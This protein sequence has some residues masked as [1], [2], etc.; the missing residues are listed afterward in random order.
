MMN[1][2]EASFYSF[3][4]HK[5]VSIFFITILLFF[6]QS[7]PSNND[8]KL[9][10]SSSCGKI[11]NISYPFRLKTDPNTCGDT[12][13]ELE[14]HNNM[15]LL[16][17]LFSGKYYVQDIDYKK[18]T[19]HVSDV[20]VIED[21]ICSFIPSYFLYEGSFG[22][23]F[24]G[25]GINPFKLDDTMRISYFNCSNMIIDDDKYVNVDATPCGSRGHIYVV[26]DNSSN[27]NFSVKDIKIGCQLK[28][29]T[30][31]NWTT[32]K[33]DKNKNNNVSYVD[34]HNMLVY[35]FRLSWLYVI[36]ED[37]CGKGFECH[38]LD[39]SIGEVQCNQDQLCPY[40]YDGP[41]KFTYNC[42][43]SGIWYKIGDFIVG[44]AVGLYA[45]LQHV[46]RGD[47]YD[48]IGANIGEAMGRYIPPYIIVRYLIGIVAFIA[49][50][51]YKWRIRHKS[52]Y[53][54]IE[55]FLEGDI[56]MPIRY[57][58]KEIK[59][60]SHGFKEKLGQGGFGL[61]YKGK[62]RS[63]SF[64]AIKMLNKSKDD[65]QDFISEVAT[66]G[67]I[68]HAN[69]VR[70]IGFCV[71]GSTKALVYEF[72]PNGS[73][74]KYIFSKQDNVLLTCEKMYEI[75]LGVAHAISY[76]HNGCEMQILHFDI[77]PH[78]ILLDENF[79]PK[80]SDFGLAKLYPTDKNVV[81]VTGVRGTLGYMA[82]ELYYH[83]IGGVSYKA[84]VY[85]FGMLLMEMA[86]R[87]RNF[88]SSVESNIESSDQLYFPMWIYD[89]LD[90]DKDIELENLTKEENRVTKKMIIVALWCIQ[91]KPS[92]RP[93]TNKV[94][95]MLEEE[96]ESIEM[97]PKPSL[98][99]QQKIEEDIEKISEQTQSD[100]STC[101]TSYIE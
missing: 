48:G 51:I 81:T 47:E 96:S 95:E 12:R 5:H 73:L 27:R 32:I 23:N 57:S 46:K 16:L 45:G 8:P 100:D 98:Y 90:K 69:V 80:V 44:Y 26:L 71:E 10:P 34:I 84:D 7:S 18:Y 55:H 75:S 91:L 2:N 79:V 28:V 52:I 62:L 17:T 20:G 4:L 64:V 37:K 50:L 41:N 82:P 92:D 74:D 29:S 56:F 63:G 89:E 97:P 83:N 24:I 67:R 99:P 6:H 33:Y 21:N 19:I 13:Y 86:S 1:A 70:L 14:C 40:V 66:I 9:C 61:V 87:R 65:G 15:T 101:S 42:G 59:Q 77:K 93:S 78:N 38:V 22:Y 3:Y 85:S 11:H 43:G 36:C 76:L 72:M 35:G 60:M 94:V 53:E 88:I 49:L 68:H 25:P 31:A 54:N 30:F 58:Y 39:E